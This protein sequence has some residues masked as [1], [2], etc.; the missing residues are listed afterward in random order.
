MTNYA[1]NL[2]TIREEARISQTQLAEIIGSSK[3]YISQL[4]NGQRNINN[5]R[6]DTMQRIC[7]ALNCTPADLTR[8]IELE[9]DE[10]GKLI[11]DKL[12]LD[13]ICVNPNKTLTVIKGNLYYLDSNITHSYKSRL[14]PLRYGTVSKDAKE[15]P[16]Y[17]Y[18][19]LKVTRRNGYDIEL[20]RA[21]TPEEFNEFKT[22]YNLTEDDI[23]NEFVDV[24]GSAFGSKYAKEYTVIQVQTKNTNEV[25]VESELLKMGIEASAI[26]AGRV[27]I[28]V[29]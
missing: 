19:L 18:S 21:I 29:K 23:S 25:A 10:D 13:P 3:S 27:N 14:T 1:N 15:A 5:I 9:Y 12:Y 7:E 16:I 2:K 22:K 11:V 17:V 4:E 28:R 20:K 24:K 6:A 8:D 26:C